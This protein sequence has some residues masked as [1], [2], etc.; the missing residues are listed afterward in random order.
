MAT[1]ISDEIAESLY[2]RGANLVGFA[3][4][5]D[6]PPDARDNLPR[7]V[8]FAVALAPQIV[9]V[10]KDGP[11]IEYHAEYE[12]ANALLD[13]LSLST[14]EMIRS[15]GFT[16]TSSAATDEGVDPQTHSTRLPHK[17]VATLAGLGWVGRCAL[18]VTEQ[19]GSATRLNRVLT[20]APLPT[21]TPVTEPRCGACRAC[22][23]AC[24]GSAPIGDSWLPDKH[25][26]QFF[27][28]FACRRTAREI[29]RQRTAISD[30]FCGICIAV[31]PWT[32]AYIDRNRS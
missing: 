4:L 16:A 19:F 13:R 7:A 8:A 29:A 21:A 5:A 32:R 23:D 1:P 10:I 22:V 9:A 30:T 2:A 28:A 3:D 18:L 31:C 17:T 15:R 24:P 25:R 11:T 14:A 20:D 26:D 27:D 6:V 12:R